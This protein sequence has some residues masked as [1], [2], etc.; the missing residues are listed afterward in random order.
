MKRQFVD[1]EQRI[2]SDEKLSKIEVVENRSSEPTVSDLVDGGVHLVKVACLGAEANDRAIDGTVPRALSLFELIRAIRPAASIHFN[3]C[4]DPQWV[5]R[6]YAPR[7][8]RQC[9]ITFVVGSRHLDALRSAVPPP[10]AANVRC[11]GVPL[12][13]AY[14]THHAK[15]SLFESEDGRALHVVVGTANLVPE[16]WGAKTQAFYH[17]RGKFAMA[18]KKAKG[19]AVAVTANAIVNSGGTTSTALTSAVAAETAFVEQQTVTA[20]TSTEGQQQQRFRDDLVAYLRAAYPPSAG[21][22]HRT[23]QFWVERIEQADFSHIKDRIVA[24][25]PG[26]FQRSATNGDASCRFGHLRLRRLLSEAFSAEERQRHKTFVGQFSS[27]GSLGAR[28]EAW[29]CD[30]FLTS[31]SGGRSMISASSLKLIYPSVENVRRSLEGYAAGLSLP[32]SSQTHQKQTYLKQFLHQWRSD[33]LKRH[34]HLA[35]FP[36]QM[37]KIG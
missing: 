13:F 3:Y 8:L 19:D 37:T 30:E 2:G 9:P 26:R 22:V 35:H 28:P 31:L 12:P 16:D 1:G 10:L 21:E 18:A 27:V 5:L 15:L 4:I 36:P 20:S 14:G 33:R 17:A 24:S 25:V 6:Q 34:F 23:I 29:L 7:R 32:Y 11:V